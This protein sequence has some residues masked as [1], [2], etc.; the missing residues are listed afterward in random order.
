MTSTSKEVFDRNGRTDELQ[1]D[2]PLID[3]TLGPQSGGHPQA[4][5]ER[6]WHIHLRSRL[7]WHCCLREP[8]YVY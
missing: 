4:G 6:A 1:R 7:R 5:H 3:G 2:A 8:Y